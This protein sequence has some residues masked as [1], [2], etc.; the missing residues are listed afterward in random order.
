MSEN[1]E[2]NF[3]IVDLSFDAVKFLIMLFMSTFTF[4]LTIVTIAVAVFSSAEISSS[5]KALVK[6][7]GLG[8][9]AFQL[10]FIWLVYFLVV[11]AANE[12]LMRLKAECVDAERSRFVRAHVKLVGAGTIL[13]L[14]GS[15]LI[16]V[17]SFYFLT[18]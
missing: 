7:A 11:R 12:L 15:I 1:R 13:C 9:S 2:F 18:L 10:I 14:G 6:I 17:T 3:K 16:L 5:I 8:F 4:Y